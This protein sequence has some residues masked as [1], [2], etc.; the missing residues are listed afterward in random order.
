MLCAQLLQVW[1]DNRQCWYLNTEKGETIFQLTSTITFLLVPLLF[2]TTI[3][4]IIVAFLHR[5]KNTSVYLSSIRRRPDRKA[6]RGNKT[7]LMLILIVLAYFIS[8]V[9]I[10]IVSYL[11]LFQRRALPTDFITLDDLVFGLPVFLPHIPYSQSSNI[12][13]VQRSLPQ[14]AKKISLILQLVQIF[15]FVPA[16]FL[17]IVHGDRTKIF[18]KALGICRISEQ[19]GT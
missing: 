12:F 17:Q 15:I 4:T 1:F 9:P 11:F 8:Y 13:C 3:Y 16:E 5:R 10:S 18:Q 7:T 2:L 14:R 6:S 19:K